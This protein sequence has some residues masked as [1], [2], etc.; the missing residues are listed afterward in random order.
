M[1][2]MFFV[3]RKKIY[4]LSTYFGYKYPL[5]LYDEKF[6]N[7]ND[8][9]GAKMA[10]WFVQ[11]LNDTF[12]FNSLIDIGCGTGQYLRA[13]LKK[14]IS[15]IMGI[16]GSKSALNNLLV[17]KGL[18]IIHDL[19][20]DYVFKRK[21]N[22]AISIEVA[23]HIDEPYSDNYINNLTNSSDTVIITAAPPGQGGTAHVNEQLPEWWKNQFLKFNYNY[24]EEIT[25]KLKE[26]ILDV[27]NKGGY[28]TNW[29]E[30]N[31]MVFQRDLKIFA[32]K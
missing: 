10:D 25:K 27:K 30:P 7:N 12:H 20:M 18:V 16:E 11:V 15:D 1:E 28:V 26:G 31:I 9:D 17:D 21:W 2:K 13:C 8:I 29:F 5:S 4:H 32:T 24:N 6:F 23:E 3:V 19:R 14:G 22:I